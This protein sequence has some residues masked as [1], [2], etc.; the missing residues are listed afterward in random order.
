M[1]HKCVSL[2]VNAVFMAI[3]LFAEASIQPSSSVPA[4]EP[5]TNNR[6]FVLTDIGNEPDDQ[7][8]LVRLLVYANEVDIEGLVATTSTWQRNHTQPDTLKEIIESYG[9]V[10][11]NL[12]Q[13]GTGWPTGEKLLSLVASGQVAYGMEAVGDGKSSDGSRALI[14]AADRA[15][16]RPL[17]VSLWGGANTLAQALWDVRASRSPQ[18]V[19]EFISRLRVY[20][21]SDQDD[22]GEWI[23]REFPTIFYIVTP[24]SQDSHDYYYATWTG[25]AGDV[26]YRNGQGADT[27]LITNEWLEKNIRKGPLGKHYLKF[28]YIM[29]GDTP[30]FMGLLNNGLASHYSPSWGGWGGRYI[31]R[32]PRG[33]ARPIWTQ[34][35]A[36]LTS[37]DEV[38]G[39][40]GKTYV[41]D[42]ATI[43]R[44]RDA[45]QRD[46]AARMDWTIKPYTRANHH[47]L[48]V[49]NK[50]SGS[51]PLFVEVRLGETLALDAS[52]SSDPD[53]NQLNYRWIIYPE[54]GYE[55]GQ[56]MA[57]V[58]LDKTLGSRVILKPLKTCRGDWHN[59]NPSCEAG[60]AHIILE[61]T[62]NGKP[63]LTRYRRVIVMVKEK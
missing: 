17:W 51:E 6:L 58:E 9:Q 25:I 36:G 61:V 19:K 21:I 12:M 46:F 10:R 63:A 52:S 2:L 30:A 16:E 39:I 60:V 57:S 1:K 23:R 5:S 40:D 33:E 62:D 29:E 47:P 20:S 34:G 54:A 18:E 48:V 28:D 31:Y 11:A 44:W 53:G 43:W 56:S 42:Q 4:V 8:S 3:T 41:S 49:I 24:S 13:H 22:A 15:D 55:P 45:F 26:F 7:M 38:T 32:Q 37:Q 50:V 14:N 27:N 35:G 59:K